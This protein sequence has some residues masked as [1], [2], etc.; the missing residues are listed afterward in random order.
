MNKNFLSN[1]ALTVGL[2]FLAPVFFVFSKNSHMVRVEGILFSCGLAILVASLI[3][4]SAVVVMRFWNEI[5]PNLP[6]WLRT[7][8]GVVFCMVIV[9][10]CCFFLQSQLFA[11]IHDPRWLRIL[12]SRFFPLLLLLLLIH[13]FGFRPVN[14]FLSIFLL[15]STVNLGISLVENDPLERENLPTAMSDTLQ[16]SG[17]LLPSC[18]LKRRPNI[19]LFVLESYHSLDVQREAYNINTDVIQSYL[20]ENGFIDYGKI[21]SNSPFTLGSF[22]DLFG[23][24]PSWMY[25]HGNNDVRAAVRPM[26]DGN[27][28][29]TLFRIMKE[30]GYSTVWLVGDSGYYGTVRGE[31]LDDSDGLIREGSQGL[32]LDVIACIEMLNTR[33]RENSVLGVRKYFKLIQGDGA[34]YAGSLKERVAQALTHHRRFDTPLFLTFKGGAGHTP[35]WGTY[36]WQQRDE[37]MQSGRYQNGV[38][39]GL[40]EMQLI[41]NMLIADDPGALIILI[42]DHGA[43][44]FRGAESGAISSLADMIT[45]VEG[46][47]ISWQEFCDDRFAVFLA[48]RLPYGEQAD[49]SYGKTMSHVNLFRHVFAYL[50]QDESILETREPSSSYLRE[51][52]VIVDGKVVYEP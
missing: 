26:L 42:G 25:T 36:D 38:K 21:Y 15:L 39:R 37:W 6:Q 9:E 7:F 35:G 5:S 27:K 12:I 4:F 31:F 10:T 49:I 1:P 40:E 41:C 17:D 22:A 29:N 33:F 30:N 48:I 3:A 34:Y 8:A 47:G 2:A 23:F 50:N 11:A 14:T 51:Q 45:L 19:Y 16:Q 20:A 32:I 28:F 24:K 44:R 13:K 18:E 43:L 46:K 52:A